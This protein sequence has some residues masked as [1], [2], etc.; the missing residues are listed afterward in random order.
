MHKIFDI[1][2]EIPSGVQIKINVQDKL[3]M[4]TNTVDHEG[5]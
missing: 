2:L 4:F 3:H 1:K 5:L